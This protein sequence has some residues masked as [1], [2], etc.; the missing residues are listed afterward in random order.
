MP[1]KIH[2]DESE[3]IAAAKSGI[4]RKAIAKQFGC[5]VPCIDNWLRKLGVDLVPKDISIPLDD[6]EIRRL[7]AD[8]LSQ[9]A[10]G[11]R[12][13]VSNHT[14][15][16]RMKLLDLKPNGVP[17]GEKSTSW[18]GG[19]IVRY[20]YVLV[21]DPSHP[22]AMSHGYVREHIKIMVE[23]IGRPLYRGENVHHINGDRADNRIENLQLISSAAHSALHATERWD[24]MDD[25]GR[26]AVVARLSAS[27]TAMA[28]DG[29]ATSRAHRAWRT[30]R[31]KAALSSHDQST[32]PDSPKPPTI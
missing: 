18:K 21:R 1:A 26:A 30:K 17:S 15:G 8:G 24:A 29:R 9:S 11:K 7:H 19:R 13:D 12:L 6:D 10:I 14:I 32:E 2:F 23:L 28:K 5:S 4:G 25:T 31:A 22:H 16:K 27:Q 20:G 3:L